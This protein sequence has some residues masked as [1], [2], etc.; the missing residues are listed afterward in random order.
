MARLGNGTSD[1]ILSPSF[2]GP[3]TWSFHCIYRNAAVPQSGADRNALLVRGGTNNIAG[4]SWDHTSATF[5]GAVVMKQTAGGFEAATYN[6]LLADT[7][8]GLGGSSDGVNSLKAWKNGVLETEDATALAVNPGQTVAFGVLHDPNGGGF[9]NGTIAESA[10]WNVELTAE[11]FAA[12]GAGISPDQIRPGALVVCWRC[13]RRTVQHDYSPN[14]RAGTITGTTIAE[15]PG[16]VAYPPPPF[17]VTAPAAAPP[18][19]TVPVLDEGML[20]GGM[21]PLGGGFE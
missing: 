14:A 2:T 19:V 6:T 7:W 13:D 1:K 21:M 11:E 4:F 8:Y 18:G 15:H 12:L 9:D 3:V 10:F 20:V 16:F 17:I 5:R